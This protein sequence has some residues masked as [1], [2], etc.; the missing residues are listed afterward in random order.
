MTAG[1]ALPRLLAPLAGVL[2][3]AGC[4]AAPIPVAQAESECLAQ[5]AGQAMRPTTRI[6][7]G[8]G[9]GPHGVHP[10]AGVSVGLSS[11]GVAPADPAAAYARCV[12]ARAG[13]PPQRDYWQ[14]LGVAP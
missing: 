7:I 9:A 8:I 12:Q 11:A 6:G 1:R 2:L 5:P 10:R 13:Q 3:L 4:A 14:M